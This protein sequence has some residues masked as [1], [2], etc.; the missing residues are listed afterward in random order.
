MTIRIALIGFGKIAR[1]EHLPAIK[2]NPDFELVAI[3]TPTKPVDVVCP[4]FRSVAD[5][6]YS[7][8]TGVDA[9][10]ICT[11]PGPRFAIATEVATA[12]VAMLLEKPP[13]ATLGELD[14]LLQVA[15]SHEVPIFTAWHSQYAAAV[16]AARHALAS[17]EIISISLLWQED[18][19][20]FHAG[21]QWIWEA[22]GFGVF[23]P[24][25]N[26]L[27]ILTRIL[28]E[29]LLV[30]DATLYFPSNKQAP[31]ATE[32][33]FQGSARTAAFDWRSGTEEQWS[34]RLMTQSGKIV[35]I[36]QGGA[37][38]DIDG[39][40][41]T[42]PDHNEYRGIYKEF[43]QIVKSRRSRVDREPLRIVADCFLTGTRKMV[44][45]FV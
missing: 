45:D 3:V 30:D 39:T 1:D 31:I 2:G 36:S 32:I 14:M 15:E 7:M 28:D 8:P 10:A 37:Q 26:G 33:C 18:V 23:D 41:Q 27:S 9:V 6:F 5:M 20:K 19:R 42:L 17:E 11:P 29:P 12:G 13:A 38:L 4:H 35:D 25:I 40:R 43:A 44:E 34:I 16:D 22:G 24:G 21:Q